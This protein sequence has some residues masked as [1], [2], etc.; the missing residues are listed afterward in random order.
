MTPAGLTQRQLDTLRFIEARLND[1][2]ACPSLREIGAGTGPRSAS[3]A[4]RSVQSLIERG[5]LTRMGRSHRSL[6]VTREAS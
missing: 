2:S 1:G 3:A 4:H 5:H 6:A